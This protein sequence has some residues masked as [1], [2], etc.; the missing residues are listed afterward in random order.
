M[1][2]TRLKRALRGAAGHS[3]PAVPAAPPGPT[4]QERDAAELRASGLF[5][6][7]F[8]LARYPDVA[9]SGMDPAVHYLSVGAAEGRDPGPDFDWQWYIGECTEA[10]MAGVNPL[11]HYLRVGRASG[12]SPKAIDAGQAFDSFAVASRAGLLPFSVGHRYAV[13]RVDFPL[14]PAAPPAPDG[15]PAPPQPL[16]ARIGSPDLDHMAVVGRGVHDTLLRCLPEGF[17]FAGKRCLDYGCGIGRVIRYFTEEARRCEFWGCD[18]D[19]PSIRWLTE[20]LS[21]PFRFYRISPAP[22]LPFEDNS[23]DLVYAVGVFSQVYDDWHQLAVELRRILKPGGTFILTFPGQNSYEDQL[24][25][26]FAA[27]RGMVLANPFNPWS[28]GG[29]MLFLTPE[30][31]QRYWG[32]I[33]DIDFIAPNGF[34]DYDTLAVMRKPVPGA[35]MRADGQAAGRIV[36]VGTRQDFHPDAFGM[37]EQRFDPSKP[38][39]DSYG[40][41]VAPG[42]AEVRGFIAM[43]RGA[44]RIEAS[45]DGHPLPVALEWSAPAPHPK[46]AELLSRSFVLR[47]DTGDLPADSGT[48]R[49]CLDVTAEDAAGLRHRLSIP[50]RASAG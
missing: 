17:D 39:L 27:N 18:I 6:A 33:F 23:F 48:A 5:D 9:A 30:W 1:V 28:M 13:S 40:L 43:R 14:G 7:G 15:R 34:L 36:E 38:Y 35:P 45:V 3:E 22:S 11:L 32:A 44:E 21:P 10:G 20:Q 31:V 46:R 41:E 19:G 42:A 16:S 24:A 49:A 12:R 29:P 25:E 37:I 8:Y 26:P 4:A 50:L 47:F 2:G